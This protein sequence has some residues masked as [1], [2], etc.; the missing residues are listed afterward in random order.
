MSTY[1][2]DKLRKKAREMLLARGEIPTAEKIFKLVI[3]LRKQEIKEAYR[4]DRS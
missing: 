2:V 4:R 1:D 3:W